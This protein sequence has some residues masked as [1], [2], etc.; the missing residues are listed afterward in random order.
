MTPSINESMNYEAVFR[1]APATPG[2]LKRGSLF[3]NISDMVLDQKSPALSVPVVDGH[4]DIA[5]TRLIRPRGRCSEKAAWVLKRDAGN[6]IINTQSKTNE[7]V[8]V[9][10][11]CRTPRPSPSF[12]T[13]VIA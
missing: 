13:T 12:L 8:F 5:D 4:T 11:P 10:I 1:T 9:I 7:S 6:P 2:L 3:S